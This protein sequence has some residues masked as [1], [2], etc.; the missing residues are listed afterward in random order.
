[1]C[2]RTDCCSSYGESESEEYNSGDPFADSD[3]EKECSGAEEKECSGAEEKESTRDE[4]EA[5]LMKIRPR[6]SIGY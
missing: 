5:P 4:D 2:Q 3:E 6:R 1:M